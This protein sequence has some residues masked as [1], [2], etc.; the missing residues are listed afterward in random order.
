MMSEANL[1]DIEDAGWTFVGAGNCPTSPTHVPDLVGLDVPRVC[2]VVV[3]DL[4]RARDLAVGTFTNQELV[5]VVGVVE[6]RV[7][8][9]P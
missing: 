4:E 6:L 3:P 5:P 9:G 7:Q 1:K 8:V 2:D